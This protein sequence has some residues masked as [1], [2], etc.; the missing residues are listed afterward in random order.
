MAEAVWPAAGWL[1]FGGPPPLA[2][3][4]IPGTRLQGAETWD[5]E[6]AASLGGGLETCACP[7]LLFGFHVY[8]CMFK[9]RVGLLWVERCPQGH[10]ANRVGL[11]ILIVLCS[12]PPT[13]NRALGFLTGPTWCHFLFALTFRGR[14]FPPHVPCR[15]ALCQPLGPPLVPAVGPCRAVVLCPSPPLPFRDETMLTTSTEPANPQSWP[16]TL[17]RVLER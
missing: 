11:L 8:V 16:A 14:Q 10:T 13:A 15:R 7:M 5:R 1:S 9:P 3:L 6:E 12:L 2:R 4:V 17:W